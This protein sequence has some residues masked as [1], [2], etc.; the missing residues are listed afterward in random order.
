[1]TETKFTKALNNYSW[2]VYFISA[3]FVLSMSIIFVAVPSSIYYAIG[4]SLLIL[5]LCRLI[6]MIKT[7]SGRLIK[8]IYL[9]EMIIQIAIGVYFIYLAYQEKDT[10]YFRYFIGGIVYLRGLVHFINLASS[11]ENDN[12]ILFIIHIFLITSGTVIFVKKDFSSEYV[13]I[14]L[15]FIGIMC[16]LI[17]VKKG[18]EKYKKYRYDILIKRETKDIKVEKIENSVPQ[19]NNEIAENNIS[20]ES[21]INESVKENE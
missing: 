7:A 14:L 8:Y 10:E 15:M 3:A 17:I 18:Y 21:E 16:S 19:V 5:G 2:L 1:M 13:S 20:Q 11:K 12:V 4:F 9:A 6:P